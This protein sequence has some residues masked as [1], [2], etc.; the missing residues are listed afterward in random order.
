MKSPEY[1]IKQFLEKA[2]FKCQRCSSCCRHVPGVVFL[3]R[4]DAA[5][6]AANL[7]LS[8]EDFLKK[9]CREVH[10]SGKKV[11]ALKEKSNYDCIFWNN[12]CIVYEARPVQCITYP[13]WPFVVESEK[14]WNNES[15]RC[16]GINSGE[17]I[18]LEEKIKYF[19]LENS[20][21]YMEFP[22]L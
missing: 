22:D 9:C 5:K 19:E 13:Y 7:E 17:S 2:D 20:I 4:E 6:I 12:G 16:I 18:P 1:N 3:S 10:R 21:E 11:V 15:K 8:L 14:S